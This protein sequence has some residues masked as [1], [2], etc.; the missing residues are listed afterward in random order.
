MAVELRAILWGSRVRWARKVILRIFTYE[1]T[2]ERLPIL[3]ARPPR[4]IFSLVAEQIRARK[5]KWDLVAAGTECR[6]FSSARMNP[7]EMNGGRELFSHIQL[8][9]QTVKKQTPTSVS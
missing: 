6:D 3:L 8:L 5:Q 4:D 1:R 9:I 7:P 2:K